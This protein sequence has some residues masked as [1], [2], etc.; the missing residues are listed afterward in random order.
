MFKLKH[1]GA[2]ASHRNSPGGPEIRSSS[3]KDLRQREGRSMQPM[4]A[5]APLG[6]ASLS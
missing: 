4:V 6:L 5:S 2:G 1:E 3:A